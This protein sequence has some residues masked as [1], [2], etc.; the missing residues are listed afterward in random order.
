M[1]CTE[2]TLWLVRHGEST[3]NALGLVQ[4]HAGEP[5]LTDRGSAQAHRAARQLA[6]RPIGAV[7]S[8]DLR[9]AVQTAQ[10][11]ADAFGLHV[12]QDVRLR[13]RCLGVAEGTRTSTLGRGPVGDRRRLGGRSGRGTQRWRVGAPAL[14]TGR[15]VRAGAQV[16][17]GRR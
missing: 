16:V 7:Y 5:V 12:V 11:I 4:G 2:R 15:R 14:P 3:W 1:T 17:I 13:E 10:A 6:G 9:R 8:S